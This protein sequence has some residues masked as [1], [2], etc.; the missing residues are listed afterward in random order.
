[1]T[2]FTH[3]LYIYLTKFKVTKYFSHKFTIMQNIIYNS[4]RA[5]TAASKR[6]CSARK[7]KKRLHR[8]RES[9]G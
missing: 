7:K 9:L 1:M 8:A 5:V 2:F 6:A 4:D 3:Q